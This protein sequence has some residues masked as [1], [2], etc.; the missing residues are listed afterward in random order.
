MDCAQPSF[1]KCLGN[2]R[3]GIKFQISPESFFPSLQSVLKTSSETRSKLQ[4][5]NENLRVDLDRWRS[6]AAADV[7]AHC[8]ALGAAADKNKEDIKAAMHT[9][10]K[11]FK[12]SQIHYTLVVKNWSRG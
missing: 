7:A 11:Y 5:H 3:I 12:V 4:A 8:D 2:V 10:N 1:G 6:A 9:Q